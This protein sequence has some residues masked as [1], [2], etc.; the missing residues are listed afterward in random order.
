MKDY[1]FLIF[2]VYRREVR[3]SNGS[4]SHKALKTES[5]FYGMTRKGG[6]VIGSFIA[7]LWI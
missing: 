6:R 5:I 7:M 2:N 3:G 4:E 1:W